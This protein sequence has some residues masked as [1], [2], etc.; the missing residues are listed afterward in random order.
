MKAC[1]DR[2]DKSGCSPCTIDP[3]STMCGSEERSQ[4]NQ[5]IQTM[6]ITVRPGGGSV[7]AKQMQIF[8]A[9]CSTTVPCRHS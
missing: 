2:V 3:S 7:R 9:A 8:L 1:Q 4:P 6:A 5:K